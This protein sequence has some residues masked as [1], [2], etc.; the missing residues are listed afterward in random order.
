[1]K[2]AP[3][4]SYLENGM[5][6]EDLLAAL[7]EAGMD[8]EA[9]ELETRLQEMRKIDASIGYGTASRAIQS[10][11]ATRYLDQ[12]SS[13]GRAL[14][15]RSDEQVKELAGLVRAN[16]AVNRFHSWLALGTTLFLTALLAVCAVCWDWHFVALLPVVWLAGFI[17]HSLIKS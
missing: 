15:R 14:R 16:Q 2:H 8:A 17:L 11:A 1:M 3:A 4:K 6:A 12:T 10:A 7:I 13:V 9:A 5:E